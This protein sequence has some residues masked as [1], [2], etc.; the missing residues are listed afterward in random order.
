VGPLILQAL[1]DAQPSFESIV[2]LT[3]SANAA[4]A[5]ISVRAPNVRTC[6]V[7]YS[8][9]ESLLDAFRGVDAVISAIATQS[10]ELQIGIIDAA[11]EAGVKF[12]IPS[13]FG[14]ANTH[15]KLRRDFPIFEDKIAI[16]DHLE[17]LSRS[18]GISYALIFVGL[19]LDWGMD[20]FVLDVKNKRVGFWDDG[21]RP[22]SMT[23]M[24]SIG[25]AVLG[26]L[27]GRVEGKK[28]VRVKDINISQKRLYELAL[29]VV[30]RGGWEVKTIN[31]AQAAVIASEKLA[32]G[33]AE[34]DD[35]YA[36]VYRA[37]TGEGY[38][39]PWRPEEDDSERLGLRPWTENDVKELI[40]NIIHSG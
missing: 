8:S 9:R 2:V 22:V 19:F 27:E 6:V 33:T 21:E 5:A 3:R 30:G 20:G 34:L 4:A 26:V 7:D 40:A 16:Q 1:Q 24:A 37:S 14:L 18:H 17:R 38:G 29:E 36:F 32:K 11:V 15:P 28:E 23:T 31:T 13:E 25:K 35:I 39:Q 10:V 12:F